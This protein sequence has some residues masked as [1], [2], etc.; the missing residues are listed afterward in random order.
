MSSLDYNI[1]NTRNDISQIGDSVSAVPGPSRR[2]EEYTVGWICALPIELAAARAMLDER[3]KPLP[4]MAN[5]SN[6]YEYGSMY[7]H[8]IVIACLPSGE[9][10][11][12]S[13]TS[14]AKDMLR[15]FSIRVGLMVGIGGGIP[16][17][18][19]HLG[20]VV[21]SQPSGQLGGV[22]Q[23]DFG[24]SITDGKFIRTGHL[25]S[26]TKALLT[27][28]SS[29]RSDVEMHGSQSQTHIHEL[30]RKYPIMKNAYASSESL[31]DILFKAEDEHDENG[32]CESCLSRFTP[33]RQSTGGRVRK[34]HYGLIASGNQVMKDAKRRDEISNDMG[35]NVLCFEME[36]AGLM[37]DF[38][39]LVIRGICDYSD[40]HKNK[41]WQRYA[42][43]TAAAE[44]KELLRHVAREEVLESSVSGRS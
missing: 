34:V 44:A 43:A 22:V 26:P 3:H 15:S 36:A 6:V 5:D 14:V 4:Q 37:N 28:L 11:I 39:C 38:P 7:G 27:A 13:A 9:Y 17:H 42:A 32:S 10:G 20:D 25:N 12:A 16:K 40:S 41:E 30:A 29:L 1:H 2:R 8:D 18:G 35:G 31:K 21:I 24:K 19:I 23:Y 33:L